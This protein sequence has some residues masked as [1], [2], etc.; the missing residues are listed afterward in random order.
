VLALLEIIWPAARR[1][2]GRR[3]VGALLAGAIALFLVAPLEIEAA[4]RQ[5]E[6]LTAAITAALTQQ[7]KQLEARELHPA[8]SDHQHRRDR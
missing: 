1:R 2:L 6:R 8:P 7:F 4:Q 3:L 5:A